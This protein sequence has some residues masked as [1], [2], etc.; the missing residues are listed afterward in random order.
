MKKLIIA[1]L[2]LPLSALAQTYPSPTFNSVTLQNPLTPA[3]GGTGV[4]NTGTITLGG[5]LTTTG[6]NPL[7][8]TTTGSTNITLP[9]SGT[10][11]NSSSGATA[12]ANSN[13][14]SLSGLTTPLSVSQGGTGTTASTGSGSVVF[15]TSPSLAS[16]SLTGSPTA[17][18]PAQF[19]NSTAI[20]TTAFVK[21][22]GFQYPSSGGLVFSSSATL[23]TSQFNNWGIFNSA[24][25]VVTL[26]SSA[27]TAVGATFTFMGGGTGGTVSAGGSDS[28]VRSSAASAS[29]LII[30][31][32][33]TFTITNEGGGVWYVTQTGTGTRSND[34]QNI[35]NYGADPTGVNDNSAAWTRALNAGLSIYK[36]VYFP[37]GTY[38]FTSQASYAANAGSIMV[39]G[40]G[41]NLST[42][43]FASGVSGIV[44][45]TTNGGLLAHVRDLSVWTRG[46]G[47]GTVGMY[48]SNSS[49]TGGPQPQEQSDVTNVTIR[50]ADGYNAT[51]FWTYGINVNGWSQWNFTNVY[52]SGG[53]SFSGT[54]VQLGS[55]NPPNGIVYNFNACTFNFVGYGIVYG[56]NIQ[57]VT[58][59][60]SNF[61]TNIGIYV[62]SGESGLDQLA[63]V[64]SQFGIGVASGI[65]I[66][67]NSFLPNVQL[68]NNLFIIPGTG[69]GVS[70]SN[71]GLFSIV[72]N[73]FNQGSGVTAIN[74]I[75]V[76]NTNGTNPGII[77][78]N[79]FFGMVGGSAVAL[80]S[81]ANH[82]N[83]QSNVYLGNGTN[84]SN[85]CSATCTV[86]GGSP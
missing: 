6:A 36:C 50:G 2:M 58:V 42:L 35:L 62:P 4:A 9:T 66:S 32:A 5:N 8:L 65:G 11:L 47:S 38:N 72:G 80:F 22:A 31:I 45:T 24:S 74:G 52:V 79:I 81:T 44:V 12:G 67:V 17:S 51:N 86:G 29:T 46:A 1:A 85:G 83:V 53:S 63:V 10:L 34:C 37:T 3:N 77:T 21:A 7:T 27:S 54:A 69:T 82:V 41:P 16:P 71:T 70:L 43:T 33:S 23:T 39:V 30:P 64:N 48:F 40:D 78:G 18:T 60:A 57:G 13:I 19:T 75:S 25:A 84:V 61:D 59:N 49:S 68:S 20:A 76:A 26:P 73:S 15:A 56:N 14:T 28:I 55:T